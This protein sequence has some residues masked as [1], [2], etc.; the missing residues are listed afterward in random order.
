MVGSETCPRLLSFRSAAVRFAVF[1]LDFLL[2]RARGRNAV[3]PAAVLV[4]AVS[5]G[6]GWQLWQS[7]EIMK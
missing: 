5:T 3:K 2:R 1:D 7:R 6:P 4:G